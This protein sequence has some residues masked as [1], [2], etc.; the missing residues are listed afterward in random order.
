MDCLFAFSELGLSLETHDAAAPLARDRGIL[1]VLGVEIVSKRL[2][3]MLILL[4]YS[5]EA[6]H[7]GLLLMDD[8]AKARLV[9]NNA[10][11]HVHLLTESRHAHHELDWLYI[12]RNGHK[13]CLFLFDEIGHVL[14]PEFDDKWRFGHSGRFIACCLR[15]SR[16]LD[17]LL[18]G[19]RVLRPVLH[20][21]LEQ[22]CRLI[23][24]N[25]IAELV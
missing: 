24:V 7:G 19:R 17:P 8:P 20:Q 13:L 5:C 1:V 2:E 14:Q 22:L 10:V 21:Q 15:L 3:H 18:L 6:T 25:R 12:R 9:L 4:A 11:G 23:L 16:L